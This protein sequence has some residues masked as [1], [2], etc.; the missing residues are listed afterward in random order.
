[1]PHFVSDISSELNSL[2]CPNPAENGYSENWILVSSLKSSLL[3]QEVV[4]VAPIFPSTTEAKW[5]V[6][7]PEVDSELCPGV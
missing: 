6:E 2:V 1:M 7:G 4:N 3:T 5:T